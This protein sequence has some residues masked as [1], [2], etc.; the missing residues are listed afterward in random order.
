MP[1]SKLIG[2]NIKKYRRLQ[3][4]TQKELANLLNKAE[5]SIQKYEA[6]KVD[7]PLTVLEQI[8]TILHCTIF[9][10]GSL[11][12]EEFNNSLKKE[13]SNNFI[14]FIEHNLGYEIGRVPDDSEIGFY[15]TETGKKIQK[16]LYQVINKNGDPIIVT[17]EEMD[18]LERNLLDML[19]FSI[20]NFFEKIRYEQLYYYLKSKK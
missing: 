13:A 7:I 5:S 16:E 4:L 11:S 14:Y 18:T 15:N 20:D 19:S 1:S 12:Y 6:G 8:A 10:L 2:Q 17:K 3:N 9:D